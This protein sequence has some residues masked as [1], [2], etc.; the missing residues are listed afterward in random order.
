MVNLKM[1]PFEAHLMISS[2][3]VD[4]TELH[5]IIKFDIFF[6]NQR[7]NGECNVTNFRVFLLAT[8]PV[9]QAFKDT[10]MGCVKKHI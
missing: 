8:S 4:S 1:N 6:L 5:M 3:V 7:A 9:V 2:S 10:Q